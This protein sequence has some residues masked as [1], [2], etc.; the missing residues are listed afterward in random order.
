M[1]LEQFYAI[2]DQ[3]TWPDLV[4]HVCAAVSGPK[5]HSG[6][7]EGALPSTQGTVVLPSQTSSM[8]V[9]AA[10]RYIVHPQML[11]GKDNVRI[12]QYLD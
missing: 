9:K 2:A 1:D 10:L 6:A 4:T 11:M 5:F 8:V 12:R 3:N 7:C